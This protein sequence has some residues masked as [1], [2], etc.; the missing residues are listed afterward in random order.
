[1]L[2]PQC[3]NTIAQGKNFCTSC[4]GRVSQNLSQSIPGKSV[5]KVKMYAHATQS[6]ILSEE[7]LYLR[8][9]Y[10]YLLLSIASMFALGYY[11]FNYVP[12]ENW[13]ALGG[14]DCTMWVLCGWFGWRRPII[15]T[16][17]LFT[18]VTGLFLGAL[19]KNFSDTDK[20]VIF[21]N[22]AILT[23]LVFVGLTIYVFLSRK[24]FNWLLGFL[25][26]GFWILLGS[27]YLYAVTGSSLLNLGIDIFGIIVF[28]GWILFDTGRILHRRD[29]ELIP[30]IAAFELFLDIIGLH[31][32]LL[33]LLDIDWKKWF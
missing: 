29:S 19:A 12:K 27:F 17:P 2:C 15:I 32:Y 21:I 16:F 3:G 13:I 23:I 26:A 4:G 18:I 28:T 25:I 1:M 22:A 14:M 30:P 33:D 6:A 20:S 11:S 5:P 9:T 24:E 7:N 31:S 10:S 8:K